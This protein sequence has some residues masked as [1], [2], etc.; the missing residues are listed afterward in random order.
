MSFDKNIN[1]NKEI[2]IEIMNEIMKYLKINMPTTSPLHKS[3]IM[4]NKSKM[5]NIGIAKTMKNI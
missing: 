1:A 2:R 3:L 4:K 5:K